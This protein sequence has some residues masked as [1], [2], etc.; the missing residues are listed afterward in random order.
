M[1]KYS[2]SKLHCKIFGNRN[3]LSIRATEL[4][5]PALSVG[6]YVLC[7]EW[8]PNSTPN[9]TLQMLLLIYCT[10]RCLFKPK[11]VLEWLRIFRWTGRA[12]GF[13]KERTGCF[14][15]S[16]YQPGYFLA[17]EAGVGPVAWL[18][19]RHFRPLSRVIHQ[20]MSL[21]YEPCLGT[22]HISAKQLLLNE[23]RMQTEAAQ[24]PKRPGR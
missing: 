19:L 4:F 11:F 22:L 13:R 21:K 5:K 24:R 15:S 2:F 20:S 18:L 23:Y 10:K 12:R 9:V 17:R 3:C 16:Q 14:A 7:N 6:C 1:I 8:A